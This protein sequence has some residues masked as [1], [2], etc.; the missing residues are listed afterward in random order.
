DFEE[1]L[2]E[3]TWSV[4]ALLPTE[5]QQASNTEAISPKQLRHLLN[6]SALPAP[7]TAEDEAKTLK[8]LSSQLHFV[9]AIRE[10]DAEGVTPLAAV[11]DETSTATQN[12]AISVESLQEAFAQE[13]LVGNHFRR[14]K[15]KLSTVD[16]NGAEDWDV[17]GNAERKFGNYFIVDN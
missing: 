17:L 14:V 10:V 4:K 15:R 11:R 1:L 8:T 7:K 6:L 3:P 5:E 9:Q 2:S 12:L 13:E 16:T